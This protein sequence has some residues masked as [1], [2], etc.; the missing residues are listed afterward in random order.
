LG[1]SRAAAKPRSCVSVPSDH[2]LY[3][4]Y[5]S[6]T[7][8][9][10]KG[11]VRETG[12][13]AVTLAWSMGS[14]YGVQ[15][16]E[17]YWA[18]SDIGWVVGHSYIVYGPLLNG[19][20]TALYEGKPIGTPDAGEFWRI[21]ERHKVSV[22][23]TAPT[24]IRAIRSADPDAAYLAKSDASS[25]RTLFL[26]GERADPD[27]VEWIASALDRPVVDHWWQTELGW[28]A[29]ASCI[30]L[31]CE[32]APIGAAGYPVPGFKFEVLDENGL[33]VGPGKTGNLCIKE[34]LAPG[35]FRSLWRNQ[36]GFDGYFTTFPGY[37]VTGDAGELGEDGAFRVMGRTD[38]IINVA[39]HRLS[40]GQIEEVVSSCPAV[41]ECAVIG[42]HDELKGEV[43]VVFYVRS[44]RAQEDTAASN[45]IR[46][47]VRGQI[48][49]IASPRDIISVS[50]L[51]KT[52]SGKILRNLLRAILNG[53][54]YSVPQT[55]E[56]AGVI[57]QIIAALRKS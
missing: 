6:G 11:V 47:A 8:G 48:S 49:P 40:T 5:T 39:G 17:A 54:D 10:P 23:F 19:N 32:P 28:P 55:I 25:L 14:I 43:P 29:L 36:E 56:D 57:S 42:G 27:T 35:S 13:Y 46:D 52:R 2:P 9:K 1:Q 18:A 41:V 37:Y 16:R 45:E 38:D 53:E 24:G 30:G 21:V 20:A 22:L 50:A 34:P 4:L 33:K 31:G 51:P 7:T 15:P 44:A 26:A 12:G 3:I